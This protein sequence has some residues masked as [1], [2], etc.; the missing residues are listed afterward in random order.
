MPKRGLEYGLEGTPIRRSDVTICSALYLLFGISS[1]G[2]IK[3]E[4]D[5][6]QQNRMSDAFR[7]FRSENNCT[8][9]VRLINRAVSMG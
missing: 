9:G 5:G 2:S 1:N 8:C 6:Q 4:S 7:Q 3:Q